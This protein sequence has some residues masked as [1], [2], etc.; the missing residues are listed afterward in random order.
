MLGTKMG[1]TDRLSRKLDWKVGVEKNNQNQKLIKEEWICNLAEVVIKE[2]EID[3]LE[4]IKIAKGKNKEIVRIV[5]K[6]KK[7]EVKVLRKDKWQVE[8]DLVL[9]KRKVYILKDEKLRVEIIQLHC[10][11]LVEKYRERW[12]IIELVVRSNKRCGKI[13]K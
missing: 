9:K 13:Y 5:E 10:N 11:V 4:K 7:V 6:T 3:I 8:E 2:S 12:K 1:K